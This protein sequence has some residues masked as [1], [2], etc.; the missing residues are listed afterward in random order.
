MPAWRP[1]AI[2]KRE[3]T[4]INASSDA[5]MKSQVYGLLDRNHGLS[6]QMI[7]AVLKLDHGKYGPTI[8]QYKASWKREFKS[9]PALNHLKFHNARGW[10]YALKSFQ[11]FEVGSRE[12]A[13]LYQCGW[14]ATKMKNRALIL[15]SAEGRLEWFETG[16]IN[17]RVNKPASWGRVKKL[18]ALGFLRSGQIQ[19][20][21]KF[22]LWAECAKFEGAHATLDLGEPIPYFKIDLLKDSNGVIIKGGDLSHRTCIELEFC[23]PKWAER[24]EDLLDQNKRALELNQKAL[25][26]NSELL[27]DVFGDLKKPGA[28]GDLKRPDPSMDKR[29]VV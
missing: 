12:R 9:R 16:R 17:I 14:R 29:F 15:V 23:Y 1:V 5:S 3:L 20:V 26:E 10:I 28:P 21:E 24:N 8:R 2:S 27:R 18:L 13:L 7:C 22:D 4:P 6:P 19:D 11:R 25:A